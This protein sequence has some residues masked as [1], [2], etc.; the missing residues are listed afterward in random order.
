MRLKNILIVVQDIEKSKQFYHDV[1]GL[2]V[3]RDFE[4]NVILS[5]GLVLQE[6]TTWDILMNSDTV[7]GNG[8]ELFF[9]E[10]F[11]IA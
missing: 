7:V 4:E 8:T 10:I 5:E 6:K 2:Q 1:F 9:E 11:G 3:I